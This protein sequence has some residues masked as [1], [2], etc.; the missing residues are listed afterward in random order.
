MIRPGIRV[1]RL[2][3]TV[4]ISPESRGAMSLPLIRLPRPLVL[5]RMGFENL[6]LI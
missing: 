2:I 5:M 1:F 6:D 3:E 4:S